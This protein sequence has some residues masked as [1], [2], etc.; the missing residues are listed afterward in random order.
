MPLNI[1]VGLIA[2]VIALVLYTIAAIGAFRA[3]AIKRSHVIML[4]VGVFFD[5][6]ATF[7][8]ALQIGGLGRD[9]HTVLA[10]LAWAGHGAWGRLPGP[11][12]WSGR[13]N[14]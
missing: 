10:V 7:M 9:L 8:M 5:V 13:T 11:G 2:L 12:R 1:V 14:G 4:W 6:L 3:K